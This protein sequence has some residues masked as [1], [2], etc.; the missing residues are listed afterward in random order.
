M[1]ASPAESTGRILC[2]I[3]A[4]DV[5]ELIGVVLPQYDIA[6]ARTI[7]EAR[8]WLAK[9]QFELLIIG[10]SIFD[11]TTL[12]LCE[13]V[14]LNY[15]QLPIIVLAGRSG[16]MRFEVCQSGAAELIRYD[17]QTWP[18]DLNAAVQGIASATP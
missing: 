4:Q 15:P 9:V 5:C 18:S 3:T 8:L 10:D 11:G 13:F 14:H 12:D 17:S 1:Q 2:V 16:P 6:T 7:A